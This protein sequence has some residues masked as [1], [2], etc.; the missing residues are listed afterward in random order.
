[1]DN[2][3]LRAAVIRAIRTGCQTLLSMLSVGMTISEVDWKQAI[4]VTL[5][6]MLISILTAITTGLP[7]V[8]SEGF[9]FVDNSDPERTKWTLQLKEKMPDEIKMGDR[10][11]F[12]VKPMEGI[13][14]VSE[15]D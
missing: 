15:T 3:F 5:I 8:E 4:S 12:E 2:T 10:L 13:D 1:M 9:F 6:A 14:D 11:T 7:E